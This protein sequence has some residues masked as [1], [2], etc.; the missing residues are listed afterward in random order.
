MPVG[1]E[2]GGGNENAAAGEGAAA[3]STQEDLIKALTEAIAGSHP[4]SGTSSTLEFRQRVDV[5]PWTRKK[6]DKDADVYT[7]FIIF[8]S[9]ILASL[10]TDKLDDVLHWEE[11]PVGRRGIDMDNLKRVWRRESP[12]VHESLEF[13]CKECAGCDSNASDGSVWVAAESVEDP[14]QPLHRIARRRKTQAR[15]RMA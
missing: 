3:S 7:D 10:Q 15:V 4:Q 8:Q 13:A 9:S 11:V 6:G 1:E 2:D 14:D 12:Q 5:K